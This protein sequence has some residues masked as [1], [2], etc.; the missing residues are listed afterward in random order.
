[1]LDW[2]RKPLPRKYR[3]SQPEWF[4]KR[5]ISWHIGVA[6]RLANGELEI[7]TMQGRT[8]IFWKWGP[9]KNTNRRALARLSSAFGATF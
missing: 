8:S 6:T 2:A 7:L 3:E 4:R 1:M 5:G 9:N